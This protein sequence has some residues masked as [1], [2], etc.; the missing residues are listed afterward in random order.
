MD[1]ELPVLRK[2][3]L[4]QILEALFKFSQET[5]NAIVRK[6]DGLYVLDFHQD[7]E[8]HINNQDIHP[9]KEQTA[10]LKKFSLDNQNRLCYDNNPI[11]VA[12]SNAEGNS[13]ILKSDGIYMPDIKSE[14]DK[15]ISNI[16]TH[17]SKE[18]REYWNSI[19]D[20]SKKYSDYLRDNLV[21][22]DFQIVPV[23]PQ[24]ESLISLNTIYLLEQEI[25]DTQ[26]KYYI[27]YIYREGKWICLDPT[28]NT[29]NKYA[30]KS[31]S[32]S[33][34]DL[35]NY[36][37]IDL[38]KRFSIGDDGY[39]LF[40]NK[41]ISL[42]SISQD[43]NNALTTGSDG[44]AFVKDY[45]QEI[46]SLQKQ[47]KLNKQILLQEE[48]ASSGEYILSEDINEYNFIM[49]HYYLKPDDPNKAPYDA[50]SD[51]LDVDNLKYLYNNH[52]DYIL[53]H[54]YGLSTYNSKIR[55]NKN[56]MQ[57]TYYNHVCIYQIIGVR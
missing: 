47:G 41:N 52:I 11:V 27:K 15:H 6:D 40:D 13:I 37:N 8:N 24:E 3:D 14:L 43:A 30:L 57:V 36:K 20:K 34:Q 32:V 45:T 54:D 55:F 44:Y 9:T 2:E 28:L 29:F 56:K 35:D 31:D 12:V 50:K 51:M 1:N 10:V 5:N 26:E 19:L 18:D 23:L 7:F 39:L 22:Y 46:K 49:V 42:V 38:L 21:I 25:K 48:C 53:E 33:N 16:E 17:V 4:I